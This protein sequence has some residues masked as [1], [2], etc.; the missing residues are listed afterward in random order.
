MM[1]T[2][3]QITAQTQLKD[4]LKHALDEIL[5]LIT[6]AEILIGFQYTAVFNKRF[7]T[8]PLSSQYLQLVGL[9]L[10]LVTLVLIISPVPYHRI[11]EGGQDTRSFCKYVRRAMLTALIF[12]ALGLGIDIDIVVQMVLG[13][14]PA[15]VAGITAGCAA[16]LFW[17][18]IEYARRQV[19]GRDQMKYTD[20]ANEDE[21]VNDAKLSDKVDHVLTEARV[22]LPGAQALLGFQFI[23]VLAEG[24]ESLSATA[25]YLHLLSLAFI[26]LSTIL[27]MT[28]AAYHRIVE[29]GEDTEHFHQLAGRFVLAAMATLAFGIVLNFYIVVQKVTASFSLAI[30]GALLMLIM[31][32]GF[33][34]GYTLYRR[35]RR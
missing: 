22:V 5:T 2:A 13:S 34:F 24:F 19:D 3:A 16:I 33:W 20:T 17:Y 10:M 25:K 9:V 23:A 28:P 35:Q 31:F 11:V 4:Q 6:G 21:V 30:L 26:A 12:F 29:E 1:T 32:Y 27:L 8:L 7:E 14:G 18:G 15:L